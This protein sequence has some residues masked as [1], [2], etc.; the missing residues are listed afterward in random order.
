MNLLA[1]ARGATMPDDDL[2]RIGVVG[3]VWATLY[4]DGWTV[5]ALPAHRFGQME[6]GLSGPDARALIEIIKNERN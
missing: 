1:L 5:Y 4:T 2:F 3:E 6:S